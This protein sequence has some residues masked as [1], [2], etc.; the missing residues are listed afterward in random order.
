MAKGKKKAGDKKVSQGI[1]GAGGKGR[2]LSPLE[3]VLF[4]GGLLRNA[5]KRTAQ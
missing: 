4:G 5:E 1:H 2:P 3:K